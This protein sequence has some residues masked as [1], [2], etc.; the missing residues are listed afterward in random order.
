MTHTLTAVYDGSVFRPDGDVP[1]AANSRC[2]ITVEWASAPAQE[3]VLDA[4]TALA[5]T[6]DQPADWSVEHDHYIYGTAKRG[7]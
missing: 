2:R 4:L 3:S 5:G 1:V 6:L 7:A